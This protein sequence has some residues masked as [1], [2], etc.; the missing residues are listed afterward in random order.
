MQ[1]RNDYSQKEV[2]RIKLIPIDK[3]KITVN[4]MWPDW[5]VTKSGLHFF[6][7]EHNVS[8]YHSGA[9]TKIKQPAFHESHFRNVQ[10]IVSHFMKM[11]LIFEDRGIR[12]IKRF[13]YNFCFC[14]IKS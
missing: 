5:C 6:S 11:Q 2:D 3:L 1:H 10:L 9:N 14:L 13:R 4:P 7:S 8:F 12:F